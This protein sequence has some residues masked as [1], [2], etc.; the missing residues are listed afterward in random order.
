MRHGKDVVDEILTP[1][2]FA[3]VLNAAEFHGLIRYEGLPLDDD[4]GSPWP[5]RCVGCW[6]P[7]PAVTLAWE[8][9]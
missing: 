2:G 6:H 7:S 8:N 4:Q 5:C 1:E 9:S 3:A